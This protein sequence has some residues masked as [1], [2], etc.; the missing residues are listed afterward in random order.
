[1]NLLPLY[2]LPNDQIEPNQQRSTIILNRLGTLF[3]VF[4]FLRSTVE[5]CAENCFQEKTC[6]AFSFY[7]GRCSVFESMA[8]PKNLQTFNAGGI[9]EGNMNFISFHSSV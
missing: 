7:N 8:P 4:Y 3:D 2:S 5:S 9:F 1:M 6:Q